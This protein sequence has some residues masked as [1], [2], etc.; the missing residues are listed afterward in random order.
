MMTTTKPPAPWT[1]DTETFAWPTSA[2]DDV[3]VVDA[4]HY[5]LRRAWI[6]RVTANNEL[7]TP[8]FVP[9]FVDGGVTG[10]KIF[11]VR[12]GSAAAKV[13]LQ[14]GDTLETFNG[15]S[16]AAPE[17]ALE[18]YTKTHDGKRFVLGLA[19]K[20]AHIDMHYRVID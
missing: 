20:G 7:M 17:Q 5:L 8:R 11:G 2:S 4:T 6:T 18:A 16:L 3:V 12:A 10:M 15:M 9:A 19:R 13:G 1:E 14:N